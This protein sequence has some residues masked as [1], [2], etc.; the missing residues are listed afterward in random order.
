[1]HSLLPNLVQGHV[2]DVEFCTKRRSP[3]ALSI[4]A[5]RS[6]KAQKHRLVKEPWHS[7]RFARPRT[8]EPLEVENRR[9]FPVFARGIIWGI[10]PNRPPPPDRRSAGRPRPHPPRLAGALGGIKTETHIKRLKGQ[11]TCGCLSFFLRVLVFSRFCWGLI[12]GK[13]QGRPAFWRAP[14]KKTHP[15]VG[16]TMLGLNCPTDQFWDRE[17]Q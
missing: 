4:G 15:N 3:G 8:F 2:P 17:S 12:R 11:P 13:P 16:S 9:D 7:T 6:K 14:E 5:S 1:M 10:H